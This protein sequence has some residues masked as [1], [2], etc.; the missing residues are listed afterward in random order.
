MDTDVFILLRELLR[1]A[2]GGMDIEQDGYSWSVDSVCYF[3]GSYLDKGIFIGCLSDTG[4]SYYLLFVPGMANVLCR[5][6]LG[7]D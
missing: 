4:F 1:G 2:A 6:A 5:L 3:D 7:C